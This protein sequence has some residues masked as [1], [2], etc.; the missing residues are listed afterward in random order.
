MQLDKKRDSLPLYIQIK[1][2]I[3]EMIDD[4]RLVYGEMLP[5]EMELCRQY[6]VSRITVR[7]AIMELVSEEYLIRQQGK[8]TF[9]AKTR[10]VTK[11]STQV[12]NF[13][14]EM[15]EQGFES[16]TLKAHIEFIEADRK[17]ANIFSIKEGEGIYLLSRIRGGKD[18]PIVYF[19]TYLSAAAK[20]PLE[21]SAYYGSLY[22]FLYEKKI[23]VAEVKETLSAIIPPRKVRAALQTDK[24]LPVLKRCRYSY[25]SQGKLFE[26]TEGYYN[27]E[28]YTYCLDFQS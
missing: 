7:E 16:A 14:F 23:K 22:T 6:D 25:D 10:G 21:D 26:Y 19:D 17:L 4:G 11:F 13:T 27:S 18:D 24:N 8:G 28:K 2:N 9:V 12:K 5:G 1:K 15:E 3:K 20:L